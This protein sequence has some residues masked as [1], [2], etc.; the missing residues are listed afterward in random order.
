MGECEPR[1]FIQPCLL[2]LLRERSDHGYDLVNRLRVLHAVDGDA[3]AVYRALRGLEKQGMVRSSW[4]TSEAGPARRTYQVTPLGVATLDR[5]ADILEE[6][7]QT[8]HLFRERYRRLVEGS[9]ECNGQRRSP[10]AFGN[11]A[12]NGVGS[13]SNGKRRE[14]NG[15]HSH[16]DPGDRGVRPSPVS[17]ERTGH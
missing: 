14:G 15:A 11:G 6:T 8:L 17:G 16:G 10:P 7:H 4:Q 9:G 13:S 3:G 1:N 12:V 2:L 5:Q